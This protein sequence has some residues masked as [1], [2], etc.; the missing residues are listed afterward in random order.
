MRAY[1]TQSTITDAGQLVISDVPFDAGEE[2]EI[3]V[4]A[5]NGDEAG[6]VRALRDLFKTTQSLPQIQTLTDED[7]VREVEAYR[8]RR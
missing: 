3:V 7:I 4:R 6:R 1:K 2:V 5:R 8:N